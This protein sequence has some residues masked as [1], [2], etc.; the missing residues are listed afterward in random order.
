LVVKNK[1]VTYK[2]NTKPR[3]TGH[4][5]RSFVP[6]TIHLNILVQGGGGEVGKEE[7]ARGGANCNFVIILRKEEKK[8][9]A[10]Q[11]FL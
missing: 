10:G 7:E 2:N 1:V 11:E 4:T 5:R 6:F 9:G 8:R 3:G